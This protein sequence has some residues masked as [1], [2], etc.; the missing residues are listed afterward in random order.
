MIK[1]VYFA[2]LLMASLML[3]STQSA[4]AVTIG[5]STGPSLTVTNGESVFVDIVVS[6]LGAEA[7]TAFDLAVAY[8]VSVL[9]GVGVTY[10]TQ[11]GDPGVDTVNGGFLGDDPFNSWID[12]PGFVDLWDISYLYD[13]ELQDLQGDGPVTLATIEFLATTDDAEVTTQ[14]SFFWD[15]WNDVKGLNNRVII[16]GSDPVPGVVPEPGSLLLFGAGIMGFMFSRRRR[17]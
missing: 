8:D 4:M 11:L 9:D 3:F 1:R 6:D 5:F 13:W 17:A 12:G 2:A 10:G 16:P 7:V 15:E 14:L